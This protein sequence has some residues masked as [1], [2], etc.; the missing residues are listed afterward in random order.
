MSYGS[1][2]FVYGMKRIFV[3]TYHKTL[4]IALSLLFVMTAATFSSIAFVESQQIK[5]VLLAIGIFGMSGFGAALS[6]ELFQSQRRRLQRI[7]EEDLVARANE[8][9]Q[10]E[11]DYTVF[12]NLE[13]EAL[14]GEV[15]K[16]KELISKIGEIELAEVANQL[17]ASIVADSTNEL[18]AELRKKIEVDD[19]LKSARISMRSIFG[20]SE[21]RLS[22]Q[23]Q[24]L[25]AQSTTNMVVGCFIALVGASFLAAA[26]FLSNAKAC[27]L[28]TSDAAD[29]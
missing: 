1:I 10:D 19:T 29:E 14:K 12:D 5:N 8:R 3:S 15:E 13:V 28:Y 24:T 26:L 4:I 18:V 25:R 16:I 27:L 6:F 7:M 21:A 23:V 9:A 20:K 22:D 17:R 11:P 2:I